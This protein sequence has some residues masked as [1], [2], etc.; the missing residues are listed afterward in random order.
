MLAGYVVDEV[1]A[2]VH[3]SRRRV[4]SLILV[5]STFFS[6]CELFMLALVDLLCANVMS[7]SAVMMVG[8]FAKGFIRRIFGLHPWDHYSIN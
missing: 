6:L 2:I 4:I 8:M 7:S 3:R 1:D 5:L